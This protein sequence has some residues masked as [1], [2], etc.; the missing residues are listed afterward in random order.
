MIL[1]PFFG[2][3]EVPAPIIGRIVAITAKQGDTVEK[4]EILA[5]IE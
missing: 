4:G 2:P 5:F 1:S 3:T